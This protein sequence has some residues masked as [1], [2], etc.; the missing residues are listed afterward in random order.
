MPYPCDRYY[1]SNIASPTF[2]IA[3]PNASVSAGFVDDIIVYVTPSGATNAPFV[4]DYMLDN[5]ASY[6]F[7][8]TVGANDL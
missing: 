2:P 6:V 8:P 1:V 7:S 5:Q 3:D 4:T